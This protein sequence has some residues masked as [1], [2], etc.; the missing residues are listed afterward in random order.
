MFERYTVQARR[1]IFFARYEASRLGS[2]YIEPEHLLLGMLRQQNAFRDTL[3]SV[4]PEQIRKRIE[5]MALKSGETPP[6]TS[7]D[8][9]LSQHSK[10]ALTYACEESKALEH[11]SIDCGHLLLGILRI[12]GSMAATLLR[13]FG[14]E[15][16]PYREI[17]AKQMS[18]PPPAIAARPLLKA[19]RDL[20]RIFKLSML[21]E[22]DGQRLSRAGWTRKEAVGH[23][24][25]WATTHQEWFARALTEPQLTAA[26]YPDPRWLSAQHYNDM[27]WQE[28][29]TLCRLLNRIIVHVI[30]RIPEDKL[31]TPC[32]IGIAEPIPLLELIR[33]YVAHCEDIV[34][35]L[36]MRA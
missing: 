2:C 23:L 36:R 24:I 22:N 25:D 1:T 10:R 32:R 17:V 27:P 34:A 6:T 12:E 16:A 30:T 19:V 7:V 8:L 31:D 5:E 29:L 4:T 26:G 28:L 9:P 21:A 3:P 14:I 18:E 15:Y 20:E 11:V 35:Q 13:E 33:R